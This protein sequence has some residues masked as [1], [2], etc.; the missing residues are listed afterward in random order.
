MKK[1]VIVIVVLALL[2]AGAWFFLDRREE[3]PSNT[4]PQDFP[5]R[6]DESEQSANQIRYES[7]LTGLAFA[8]PDNWN[9]TAGAD[10]SESSQLFTVE[11]PLDFNEF[12][13]CLDL[14]AVSATET[15]EF[16]IPDA[17]VAAVDTLDSGHQSVLYTIN[18]LD[19]LQW[20]VTDEAPQVGG[21][22]FLSEITSESGYRLQVF[23]RFNCR[24]DSQPDLTQEEFQNAR[25][26]HEARAIINSLEF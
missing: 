16:N 4:E 26:F 21:T 19:G 11:S 3:E 15:V 17:K 23:G 24:E 2:G 14:Y 6:V 13:F 1:A 25:W 10:N 7:D 8:Y 22:G 12:Y 5:A 20:G 18:E 9:V